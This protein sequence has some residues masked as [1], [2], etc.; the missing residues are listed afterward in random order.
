MD[1]HDLQVSP[2][3]VANTLNHQPSNSGESLFSVVIPTYD[4][5]G[6]SLHAV[7]AWIAQRTE[8]TPFELIIVDSGNSRLA[9][10]IAPCLGK[11]DQLVSLESSN[12]AR[13]YN[14]GAQQATTD[15]IVFSEAHVVPCSDTVAKLCHRLQSTRCDAAVL[16]SIH[17]TRTHFARVDASLFDQE[18]DSMRALG[19][20]RMVGLR[21]FLIRR[22]V[23][24]ALGTFNEEYLRF[25]ETALAI[26]I[27]ERG[28]QLAEF[29]EV[30]TEHYDTDSVRELLVA[31]AAGRLGAH[32]FWTA[33]PKLALAYFHTHHPAK[34]PKTVPI[35]MARS[36]WYELCRS[37]CQRKWRV[38]HHML[39]LNKSTLLPAIC[40]GRVAAWKSTVQAWLTY[41]KLTVAMSLRRSANQNYAPFLDLYRSLREKCAE[42]GSI[43]FL[44]ESA[45]NRRPDHFSLPHVVEAQALQDHG[46]NFY[47]TEIYKNERYS[48]SSPHAAVRLMLDSGDCLISLDARP[49]GG[50]LV[51]NPRLF[52]NGEPI[53]PENVTEEGGIVKVM[54]RSDPRRGLG[55]AILSWRCTPFRPAD[56]GLP[57]SR[58]LGIALIC[59]EVCKVAS[60]TSQLPKACAA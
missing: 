57:D 10:K 26:H 15:W 49:T 14:F 21:G 6:V 20:W 58:S 56:S 35:G 27:V 36:I 33:E 44:S 45:Q 55:P 53:P 34:P 47:P 30:V 59:A 50:W 28:Y 2:I 12:E 25:A 22:A 23:F 32:R 41:F 37:I 4:D 46:L 5:R 19:L 8:T 3:P 11:R 13:L 40:S 24:Q 29:P 38:A 43:R 42:I 1:E 60:Q 17:R 52:I 16:G 48:W 9:R 54:I 18:N 7:Q 31:M 51:R 39:M